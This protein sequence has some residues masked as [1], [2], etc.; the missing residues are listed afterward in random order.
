MER[1]PL[2]IPIPL[3][4][5]CRE[6]EGERERATCQRTKPRA[7]QLA[8]RYKDG[9]GKEVRARSREPAWTRR[10]VTT[11]SCCLLSA[12][13]VSAS[14]D[15]PGPGPSLAERGRLGRVVPPVIDDVEQVCAL[16]TSCDRLPIPAGIVPGDFAAC[17]K[18]LA[19][20]LASP[21]AIA[22]SL[23]IRECGLRAN[24]CS[25]LR[26]C[27]L[28]GA[29]PEACTGRGKDAVAG[30]CDI[31]GRA[32]RCWHEKVVGVRD[33][34]RGGEQC[35]VRE[36]QAACSLGPC[37]KEV[38]EGAPATCSASGTRI[39]KC[40]HGVLTSLDC[41]AFGLICSAGAGEAACA[42]P[43]AACS[44]DARR[45]E[46]EVAVSCL[47]GHEVRVDCAAGGLA[48]GGSGKSVGAC[49]APAAGPACDPAAAARCEGATIRYCDAGRPRA[50]LCKSL[51]F[52]RCISD[53]NGA[54]CG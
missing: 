5:D 29:S 19:G 21:S 9:V 49:T 54:R 22:Y 3:P 35:S 8:Q 34:P 20:Q 26:T 7:S 11:L 39:L 51:G 44:G 42:S 30:Y 16:L 23:L 15:P 17:V 41:S 18:M 10:G 12:L 2:P 13:A 25:E 33:C 45:C 14:A 48:C 1:P 38:P 40:E 46:G 37:P 43:T 27:G 28:R 31:D 53:A 32:L 24:S 6:W 36:G 4:K 47:A 50:Y 52:S